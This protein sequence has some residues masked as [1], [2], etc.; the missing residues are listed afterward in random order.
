MQITTECYLPNH[1]NFYMHFLL[2]T[3]DSTDD[4]E[5]ISDSELSDAECE[6][7]R[8]LEGHSSNEINT[9]ITSQKDSILTD[10]VILYFFIVSI[11]CDRFH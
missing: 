6:S 8:R 1:T 3:D 11:L 9:N 7:P 5:I 2:P 4:L 10:K